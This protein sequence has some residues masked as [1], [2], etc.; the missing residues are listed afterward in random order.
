MA[1]M[2]LGVVDVGSSTVHLLVVDVRPGGHPTPDSSRTVGL[3]R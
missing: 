3:G 2:R 1:R